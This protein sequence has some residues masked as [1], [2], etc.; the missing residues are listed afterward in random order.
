MVNYKMKYNVLLELRRMID[1]AFMM[2]TST[3]LC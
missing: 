3:N 1:L 2:P